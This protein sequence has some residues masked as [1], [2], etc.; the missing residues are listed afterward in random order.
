MAS[1]LC[2]WQP[3]RTTLKWY[4]SFWRTA[5]ARVWPLRYCNSV[6]IFLCVCVCIYVWVEPAFT[7]L[8]SHPYCMSPCLFSASVVYDLYICCTNHLHLLFSSVS[9]PPFIPHPDSALNTTLSRPLLPYPCLSH[10]L[11]LTFLFRPPVILLS[12]SLPVS[13]WGDWAELHWL[14]GYVGGG[15]RVTLSGSQMRSAPLA[16]SPPWLLQLLLL[17]LW[18]TLLSLWSPNTHVLKSHNTFTYKHVHIWR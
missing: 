17:L 15:G 9:F 1:P 12:P 11:C 4:G 5:P 6:F 2:T 16:A 3:R 7:A 13:S 14:V 10:P 8:Q 18:F